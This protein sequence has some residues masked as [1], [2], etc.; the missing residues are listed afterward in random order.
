MEQEKVDRR[1]RKT[2]KQLRDGLAR[3]LEKKSIRDI[4]VKELVEEVDINR[5]TFYLHYSD[6]YDMLEKIEEELFLE[7]QQAMKEH[8]I[9]VDPDSHE[10][11]YQLF[12]ILEENRPICKA[13]CGPN[14]DMAF[15]VR[16]EEMVGKEAVQAVEPLFKNAAENEL[17]YI[18]A[19]CMNG[20]VGLI[21]IWLLCGGKETP[22]EMAEIT[23]HMVKNTLNEYYAEKKARATS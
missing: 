17:Q 3:L 4:R 22:A 19:Y 6:I 18:Y 12:R 23:M 14:G 5:S 13:L 20:C 1:V 2:R 9:G 8:P 11:I 10:F 7:I 21:K 15:V 16:M